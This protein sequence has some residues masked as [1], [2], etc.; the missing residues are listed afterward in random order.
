MQTPET[1]VAPKEFYIA[2]RDRFYSDWV[3][4]FW[5][6]LFQNSID[7]GSTRIDITLTTEPGK[8]SFGRPALVDEVTR[9]RF[10]DDGC[11]MDERTLR[12]VYFR[13]G[14]TTKKDGSSTGG[15]GRARLMT[16]FSQVRYAIHTRD[17]IVEG[18]GPEFACARL[19]KAIESTRLELER[20]REELESSP[21]YDPEGE[22]RF[23]RL[24]AYLEELRGL[25]TWR[26]GCVLEIDI[27]PNEYPERPWNNVTLANLR[28]RLHEYLSQS[29]LYVTG[30]NR[31]LKVFVDGMEWTQRLRKGKAV[32]TL[33]VTMEDGRTVEMATVHLNKSPQPDFEG[34]MIFRIE[35]APMLVR[36]LS[37][38]N[39]VIV[40]INKAESREF[41]TSNRDAFKK[42][43]ES[44]VDELIQE[45]VVDNRSALQEREG[46]RH[47]VVRGG[48]GSIEVLKEADLSRAL[49][50]EE[51]AR[52]L[53]QASRELVENSEEA[54]IDAEDLEEHVEKEILQAFE[55]SLRDNQA[56]FL[57]SYGDE[58]ARSNFLFVFSTVSFAEAF[59]QAPPSL[60]RFLFTQLVARSFADNDLRASLHNIHIRSENTTPAIR[61]A[62]PRYNPQRWGKGSKNFGSDAMAMQTAWQV[63]CR[64]A[65]KTLMRVEPNAKAFA[66]G[67]IKLETGWLFKASSEE[68]LGDTYGKRRTAAEYMKHGDAHVMLLNPV[69]DDGKKAYRLSDQKDIQRM[70]ALALH[71]SVHILSRRHDEYWAELMTKVTAAFDFQKSGEVMSEIKDAIG[72][73]RDIFR[74]GSVEVHEMDPTPSGQ[75]RPWEQ[76]AALAAPVASMVAGM[77][78]APENRDKTTAQPLAAAYQACI[79]KHDTP[80]SPGIVRVNCDAMQLLDERCHHLATMESISAATPGQREPEKGEIKNNI[81]LI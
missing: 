62:M 49:D 3:I 78:A 20:L 71:E 17:M 37:T 27:N 79:R 50:D 25:P 15:Y 59:R 1:L 16:C 60:R 13:P 10:S 80:E 77:A 61:R 32:K 46:T 70:M 33:Y 76:L 66:D 75:I 57:D 72:R 81:R 54:G 9:I 38:K 30:T 44:V 48:Q 19:D 14:E 12:D 41:L 45:I 43:Y 40:E 11:G 26:D 21:E 67:K 69:D 22:R 23:S 36:N 2:E 34:K 64:H 65:V 63:C 53:P 56:S 6:E 24:S 5:R 58:T 68:W 4:S 39:Q 52:A 47:D 7:A 18:D 51:I 8:G 42:R 55:A 74:Q 31:P 28:S 73:A 29:Q 35:G